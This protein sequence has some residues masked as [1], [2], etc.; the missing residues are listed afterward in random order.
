MHYRA[1]RHHEPG[2]V[3]VYLKQNKRNALTG[4][5]YLPDVAGNL[6][7]MLAR[8]AA[9]VS[10][11]KLAMKRTNITVK[12]VDF[13]ETELCFDKDEMLFLFYL[14]FVSGKQLM[15]IPDKAR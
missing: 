11:L 10:W 3:F 4:L 5:N 1:K 8:Q 2:F 14:H 6:A 9:R 15:L 13:G 12:S 7:S